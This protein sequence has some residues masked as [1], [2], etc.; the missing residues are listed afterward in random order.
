MR[1]FLGNFQIWR[2]TGKFSRTRPQTFLK[3]TWEKILC[4]CA[5]FSRASSVRRMNSSS[6]HKMV[7]L[8]HEIT[9]YLGRFPKSLCHF[10]QTPVR[11]DQPIDVRALQ[12]VRVDRVDIPR[13]QN[14][15][16]N[17]LLGMRFPLV[18]MNPF[19]RNLCVTID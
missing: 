1:T 12:N 11:F 16:K 18:K 19:L 8:P 14:R 9:S 17:W 2:S 4:K 7:G 13:V 6:N 3:L 5:R 10:Q 15:L